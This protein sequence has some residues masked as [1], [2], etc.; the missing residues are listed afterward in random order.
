MRHTGSEERKHWSGYRREILGQ[1]ELRLGRSG[2]LWVGVFNIPTGAAY[3]RPSRD[4]VEGCV[5]EGERA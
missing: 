5:G 2:Y 1:H 4:M 3:F